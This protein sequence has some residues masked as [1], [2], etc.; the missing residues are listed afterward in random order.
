M[1][2]RNFGS[3]GCFH[4][5]YIVPT[6][7]FPECT[8]GRYFMLYSP[9][10][11]AGPDTKL[12]PCTAFFRHRPSPHLHPP[13]ALLQMLNLAS[14][15][16]KRRRYQEDGHSF[17]TPAI[18]FLVESRFSRL[19]HA[20]VVFTLSLLRHGRSGLRH[21]G[22][23]SNGAA[24]SCYQGRFSRSIFCR[25]ARRSRLVRYAPL[26]DHPPPPQEP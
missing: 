9:A 13:L 19:T 24:R 16:S 25:K 10:A 2:G 17:G 20:G 22:H 5:Q 11:Q 26:Q 23:R 15:R 8:L 6:S 7:S 14:L 18:F 1:I 21:S 4:W 12:G 3:P